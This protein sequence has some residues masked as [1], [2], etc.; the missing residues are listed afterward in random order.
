MSGGTAST[1]TVSTG[2][3]GLASGATTASSGST[4]VPPP[5]PDEDRSDRA[6]S[7]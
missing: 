7:S 6:T 2:T 4:R 5:W 3:P 1:P